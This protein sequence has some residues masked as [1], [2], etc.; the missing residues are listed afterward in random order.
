MTFWKKIKAL[1]HV[2]LKSWRTSV[3]ILKDFG[4]IL[5]FSISYC[6]AGFWFLVA[7]FEDFLF[8]FLS[9]V[10]GIYEKYSKFL[11]ILIEYLVFMN[12]IFGITRSSLKLRLL[13]T[14]LGEIPTKNQSKVFLKSWSRRMWRNFPYSIQ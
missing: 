6:I 14:P 11:Q 2:N 1:N 4:I 10:T 8:G 12:L 5:L 13:P 3:L 9:S 7:R